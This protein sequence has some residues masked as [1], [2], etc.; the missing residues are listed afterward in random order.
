MSRRKRIVSTA[1]I[2]TRFY[3]AIPGKVAG[4]PQ[5]APNR[6]AGRS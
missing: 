4:L 6:P 5:M 3:A 1:L 2:T